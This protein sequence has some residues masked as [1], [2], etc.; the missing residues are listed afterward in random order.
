MK[1]FILVAMI[2]AGLVASGNAKAKD[3]GARAYCPMTHVT[4]IGHGSSPEVA[5]EAA[6]RSCVGK[7]GIPACCNKFVRAI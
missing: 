1:T 7:G 2:G 6:I 4:G 5:R 3:F